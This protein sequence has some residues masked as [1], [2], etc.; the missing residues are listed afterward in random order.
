M[1]RRDAGQIKTAWISGIGM[2]TAVILLSGCAGPST[3]ILPYESKH[4]VTQPQGDVLPLLDAVNPYYLNETLEYLTRT[5]CV[6]GSGEERQIIG[7]MQQ[8]LDDYGYGVVL[9]SVQLETDES[10]GPSQKYGVNLVAQRKAAAPDS[11]I[12]I[13]STRHDTVAESPGAG[14]RAA[15]LAVWMECARLLA[16]IPTDTQIWFVS[17]TGSEDSYAGSRAY[18]QSLRPEEKRRI[19]GVIQ[20][21]ELGDMN[22]YGLVLGSID[23]GAVMVGDMLAEAAKG[24]YRVQPPYQKRMDSDSVSFVQGQV[25]AI[26]VSQKWKA[27]EYHLPQDRKE[28]IDIDKLVPTAEIII[29]TAARIMGTE[30]PSLTAKSRFINNLSNSAYTQDPYQVQPFGDTND[31]VRRQSDMDGFLASSNVDGAGITVDA[32]QYLMKWFDVDQVIMTTYY[33]RDGLLDTISLDADGA[34]V[35]F[36]EMKER[37]ESCYGQ[38]VGENNGPYGTEYDWVSPVYGNFFA[39]IPTGEGF[40]LDIREYSAG[41]IPKAR[42]RLDGTLLEHYEGDEQRYH[43]LLGLAAAVFGPELEKHV[44][45][46]D[47]YTD[48]IG[49]LPGYINIQAADAQDDPD[50]FVLGLDG[51]EALLEDGSWRDYPATVRLL[52]EYYGRI[53]V[54]NTDEEYVTE[55]QETFSDETGQTGFAKSFCLFVL[56]QYPETIK[57]ESD[58][59]IRFFYD[60][61]SLTEIRSRIREQL[62]LVE[63]Q[64][65][66]A[67]NAGEN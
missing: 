60:Y 5:D 11:D 24:L 67:I 31:I 40:D 55:F 63:H 30:T 62:Q 44:A 21:D 9:Q 45:Y 59:R 61:Q 51:E 66:E 3:K 27:Y 65:K 52:V 35:T 43:D 46:V 64:P 29:R 10:E 8:Q 16:D 42:F 1:K 37:L 34:G 49:E 18:V 19:V 15:A 28:T 22:Q 57:H 25:P 38:P 13:I 7:Y 33:Y 6:S 50:M 48:G 41:W 32:Y 39:L 53:L 58:A 17:F 47:I 2:V 12:L 36:E 26:S 14:S 4:T 20:L 54:H 23:G 56:C